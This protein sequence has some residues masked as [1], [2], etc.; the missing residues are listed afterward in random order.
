MYDDIKTLG[1]FCSQIHT[2]IRATPPIS[3]AE[4]IG[5]GKFWECEYAGCHE[6]LTNA[7][8]SYSRR[9]GTS[10]ATPE[11]DGGLN[12]HKKVC[13]GCIKLQGMRPGR[14]PGNKG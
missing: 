14:S 8:I 9:L 13:G 10:Y 3:I 11:S 1:W 6:V 7:C 12:G 2:M 4:V 5:E